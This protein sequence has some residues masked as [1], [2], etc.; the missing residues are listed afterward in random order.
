ME[1]KIRELKIDELLKQVE[2]S[3]F[4]LTLLS[5]GRILG[6]GGTILKDGQYQPI[7]ALVILDPK[8]ST[9]TR[10]SGLQVP[11]GDDAVLQ[12]KD[13]R[14]IFIGG[15]TKKEYADGGTDNLTNTV[16]EL[17]LESGKSKV[18]GKIMVPR[19]AVI[20]EVI[21]DRDILV[22]GGWNE[23]TIARDERWWPGAEIFRV[24]P[25]QRTA[26]AENEP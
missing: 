5:D 24:P 10:L 8:K 14:V 13:G 25:R 17:N 16:E 7:S 18:I 9:V 20:A 3:H 4:N 12:L 15:E 6:S 26:T 2:N 22:V 23:R 11:R 19:H 1:K 21:S